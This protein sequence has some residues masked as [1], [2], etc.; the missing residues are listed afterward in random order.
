MALP[1]TALR[2]REWINDPL[3]TAN[4][5][6]GRFILFVLALLAIGPGAFQKKRHVTS[7]KEMAHLVGVWGTRHVV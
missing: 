2:F 6:S 1:S 7:M 3:I 4:M 5:L